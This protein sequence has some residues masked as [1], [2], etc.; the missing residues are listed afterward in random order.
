MIEA[1]L[2]GPWGKVPVTG[3]DKVPVPGGKD[4]EGFNVPQLLLDYDVDRYVD[5][6]DQPE[7]NIPPDPNVFVHLLRCTA[8]ALAQIEA[9]ATYTVLSAEGEGAAKPAG[10]K[11]RADEATALCAQLQQ[12]HGVPAERAGAMVQAGRTRAEVTKSLAA[13]CRALP[14]GLIPTRSR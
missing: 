7:G 9:D 5:S 4:G 2:L 13:W 11:L 12:R 8:E 10:G 14:A 1:M 6:T 3:G